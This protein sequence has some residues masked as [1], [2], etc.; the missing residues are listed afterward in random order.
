M[1]SP[2]RSCPRTSTRS[3]CASLMELTA[4]RAPYAEAHR[5]SPVRDEAKGRRRWES[6]VMSAGAPD[7]AWLPGIVLATVATVSFGMVLGPEA[8]LMALGT[9]LGAWA[10]SLVR[11]EAPDQVKALVAASA[12][13][14]AVSSLFGSPVIGAII[15]IE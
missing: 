7:P 10:L 15:I 5:A 6:Q 2:Q 13:F 1:R 12:A 11:K 4:M 8:P 14:A 9:G 3:A